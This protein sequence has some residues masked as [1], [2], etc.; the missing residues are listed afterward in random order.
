MQD[1]HHLANFVGSTSDAPTLE[2]TTAREEIVLLK[3]QLEQ[4]ERIYTELTR[5]LNS[6]EEALQEAQETIIHHDD[7]IRRAERRI[8]DLER[9]RSRVERD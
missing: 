1:R 4:V 7:K 9:Q 8:A 6:S 5:V 2:L 3:Y